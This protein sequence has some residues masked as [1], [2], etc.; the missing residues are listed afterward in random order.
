[1]AHVVKT[2]DCYFLID[3]KDNKIS[4]E[5]TKQMAELNKEQTLELIEKLT[6]FYN[7]TFSNLR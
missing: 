3:K 5:M 6:K 7:W 1:M 2:E 4:I